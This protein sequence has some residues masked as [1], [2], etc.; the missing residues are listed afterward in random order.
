MNRHYRHLI[1]TL[2]GMLLLM[3]IPFTMVQA[4]Q[5]RVA[6]VIGNKTYPQRSKNNVFCPLSNPVNDAKDITELLEK[7]DFNVTKLI[8]ANRQE[9]RNAINAFVERLEEGNVGILYFSGHG[10]QV[11]NK[12]YL[13][14]IGQDFLDGIDVQE[15]GLSANFF[16]GKMEKK[17]GVRIMILD[18]W[19]SDFPLENKGNYLPDDFA[20]MKA[21]GALIIYATSPGKD[22]QGSKLKRNSE[23]TLALKQSISG[24]EHLPIELVIKDTI[25]KVKENT[26]GG[27]IPWTEGNLTGYFCLGQCLTL[28]DG[29]DNAAPTLA[30]APSHNYSHDELQNTGL[31]FSST[32]DANKRLGLDSDGVPQKI[33]SSSLKKKRKVLID[34]AGGLMWQQHVSE[35][36]LSYLEALAYIEELNADKA[37]GY[38]D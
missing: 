36:P 35:K 15:Y 6:L 10:V 22:A 27:Q 20:K 24:R 18:A 7:Y 14:P 34:K 17:K 4:S 13:L 32:Q 2:P 11:Q 37:D 21:E 26:N 1:G 8:N 23:F 3:L 5:S 30:P 33:T 29:N 31:V 12:N 28:P 19:R 25:T 38:S 9:M 16:L